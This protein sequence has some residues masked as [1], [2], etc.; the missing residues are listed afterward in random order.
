MR[1]TGILSLKQIRNLEDVYIPI[2]GQSAH[3]SAGNLVVQILFEWVSNHQN[4]DDH[5][6]MLEV[7]QSFMLFLDVPNKDVLPKYFW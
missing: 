6:Q 2:V 4:W 5:R 1:L 3:Q 7:F